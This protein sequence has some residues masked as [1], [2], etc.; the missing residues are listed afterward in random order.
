MVQSI[1]APAAAFV[2]REREL[3]GLLRRL[4]QARIGRGAHR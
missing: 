2:G 3:D 1:Q 4:E